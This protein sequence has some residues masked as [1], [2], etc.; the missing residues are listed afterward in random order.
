MSRRMAL[1][2]LGTAVGAA[3]VLGGAAQPVTADETQRGIQA[4]EGNSWSET[5]NHSHSRF[6]SST[7]E[8]YYS[9]TSTL[10][11]NGGA[12]GSDP[13]TYDWVFELEGYG[14]TRRY[15]YDKDPETGFK[16]DLIGYQWAEVR[17]NGNS[18]ADT[19]VTKSQCGGTP[20]EGVDALDVAEATFNAVAEDTLADLGKRIDD[21]LL[22]S[23]IWDNIQSEFSIVNDFTDGKEFS[24]SYAD[25]WTGTKHADVNHFMRWHYEMTNENDTALHYARSEMAPGSVSPVESVEWVI[26]C[27]TPDS[28][29]KNVTSAGITTTAGGH[30]AANFDPAFKEELGLYPVPVNVLSKHGFDTDRLLRA[31]GKPNVAW[32][33]SDLD[34]DVT[35]NK[36]TKS[37]R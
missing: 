23:T 4:I 1:K 15:E 29:T 6:H 30:R 7:Y 35:V 18:D 5:E 10:K 3:T 25:G 26:E 31:P 13:D 8:D 24:W 27:N 28:W 36:R 9:I 22:L 37:E 21:L 11:N 34:F 33:A 14:G 32:W 19:S 12:V 20:T 17:D 16:V 2:R